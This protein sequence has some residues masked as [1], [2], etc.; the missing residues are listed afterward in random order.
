VTTTSAIYWDPFD[1]VIDES[2]HAIW[3]RMRDEMPLYR[4]DTFDFWALSR[5]ADVHAAH[6]DPQTYLSGYGT[7]LELM[8]T[9]MSG[10]GQIIFMD[11]QQHTKMRVLVSKAF[12]RGRVAALEDRIRQFCTE[13]LDAQAGSGGFDYVADFGAQLPSLVISSLLGVSPADRPRVLELINTTFHIEPGVGMMN[14]VS[15]NAQIELHGYVTDQLADR[16]KAPRDDLIT[17][18]TEAELT[19]DGTV[20]RLTDK[21]AAD[22]AVLLISAGTETVAKLLGW[23][24]VILADHPDQRAAMADD[25]SLVPAAVEELLRYEAP[26]PV[27]GRVLSRPVELYG[28][29]LP[30]GAKVLL[31][32]GSAGRDDRVWDRPDD[33]DI[34]RKPEQHVA[35]G[36]GAHFCL[37]A[38]LARMEGRIALE[39]TLARFPAWQVDTGNVVRLHTSTVRGYKSVPILV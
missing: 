29:T 26:S 36:I 39:E 20:R 37:G 1:E 15:F 12:T 13:L 8:G 5:H 35:F 30:K 9:D 2:P 34:K 16:R 18:L 27:Q 14:E 7:V 31:L 38:A 21:E 3:R 23:A 6:V 11:G 33:F 28:E 22:F 4:N 17:A 10:T 32:T 19:D 24:S 25:P